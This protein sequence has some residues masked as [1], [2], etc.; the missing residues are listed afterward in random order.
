MPRDAFTSNIHTSGQ[1]PW[2]VSCP[3][4]DEEMK[5]LRGDVDRPAHSKGK[6]SRARTV[7]CEVRS[8]TVSTEVPTVTFVHCTVAG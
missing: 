2:E 8:R 4:A 3:F 5:P 7:S 6:E 1:Q